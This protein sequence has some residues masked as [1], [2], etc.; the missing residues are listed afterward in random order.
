MVVT[1]WDNQ[2]PAWTY[3]ST[4]EFCRYMLHCV[5]MYSYV[6]RLVLD[7]C[8][9]PLEGLNLS[10]MFSLRELDLVG[11]SVPEHPAVDTNAGM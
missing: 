5:R 1:L 2:S 4:T 7:G 3:P 8:Q 6:R 11:P 9:L 10:H